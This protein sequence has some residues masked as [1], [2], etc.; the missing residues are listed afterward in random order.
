[1]KQANET[2]ATIITSSK[3]KYAH[4]KGQTQLW[5]KIEM[6]FPPPPASTENGP[7]GSPVADSEREATG[8]QTSKSPKVATHDVN[9]RMVK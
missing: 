6:A 4:Q 5:A 7:S 3:D 2:A 1:M 8:V 9:I